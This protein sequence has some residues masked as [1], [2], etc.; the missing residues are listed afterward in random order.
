[1]RKEKL[2]KFRNDVEKLVREYWGFQG[3][4][5][6]IKR[7]DKIYVNVLEDEA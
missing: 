5:P 7:L 2:E 1:M 3:V 6:F 4:T